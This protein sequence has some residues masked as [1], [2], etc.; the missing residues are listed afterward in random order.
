MRVALAGWSLTATL[1]RWGAHWCPKE[2]GCIPLPML[3]RF[4]PPSWAAHP[5]KFQRHW[6]KK[7]D[8]SVRLGRGIQ[9]PF[10]G[11]FRTDV[12]SG[13]ISAVASGCW[14][15]PEKLVGFLLGR[16]LLCKAK[17]CCQSRRIA[18]GE[19]GAGLNSWWSAAEV[20]PLPGTWARLLWLRCLLHLG[21][22]LNAN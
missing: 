21:A 14:C 20:L 2:G 6:H 5:P 1:D 16:C 12:R 17:G 22:K 8:R 11:L 18:M 15:S 9:L 10:L 7:G 3:G 19:D 4:N 13:R